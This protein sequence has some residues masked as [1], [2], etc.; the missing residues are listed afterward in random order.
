MIVLKK[1]GWAFMGTWYY[2]GY[3]TRSSNACHQMLS[4][5]Q[6]GPVKATCT[7]SIGGVC[8]LCTCADVCGVCCVWSVVMFVVCWVCG[9]CVSLSTQLG[10]LL[11]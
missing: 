5:T 3:P 4:K 1:V 10:Q 11:K 2:R 6:V 9:V 7:I 8:G